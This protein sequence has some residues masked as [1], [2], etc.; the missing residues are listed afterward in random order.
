MESPTA[1]PVVVNKKLAWEEKQ[2]MPMDKESLASLIGDN[3]N[4]KVKGKY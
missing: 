4:V 2:R 1:S 3:L